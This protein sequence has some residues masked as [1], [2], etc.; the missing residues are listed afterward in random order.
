MLLSKSS[1][2]AQ[3]RALMNKYECDKLEQYQR[4][5]NMR[6]F[7]LEVGEGETEETLELKAADLASGMGVRLEP[8]EIS[9]THRG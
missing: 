8:G 5:D 9:V 4:R 2:S 7:G 3:K 6:I 1:E